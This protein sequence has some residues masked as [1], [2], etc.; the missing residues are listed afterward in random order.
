MKRKP[1]KGSARKIWHEMLAT[2]PVWTEFQLEILASYANLRA[3]YEADPASTP[4]ARIAEMNR[5]AQLLLPRQ[6]RR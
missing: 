3:D 6:D 1:L 2:R 5:Q 4:K